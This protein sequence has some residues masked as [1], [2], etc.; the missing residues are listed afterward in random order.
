MVVDFIHCQP[1]VRVSWP[2]S[3]LL[4]FAF[5][6]SNFYSVWNVHFI[7][8]ASETRNTIDFLLRW[9]VNDTFNKVFYWLGSSVGF[10]S[11]FVCVYCSASIRSL[12][13]E[14]LAELFL[15]SYHLMYIFA[16][17]RLRTQ[18]QTRTFIICVNEYT[19][20]TISCTLFSGLQSNPANVQIPTICLFIFQKFTD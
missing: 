13:H 9:K 2:R 19:T 5:I 3:D 16:S 4:A 20:S 12:Q 8:N 7:I 10:Y 11:R 17:I 1:N 18:T 15:L 14:R 6:Y